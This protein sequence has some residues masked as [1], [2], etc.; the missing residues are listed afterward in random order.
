MLDQVDTLSSQSNDVNQN[1][2]SGS[3]PEPSPL[4]LFTAVSLPELFRLLIGQRGSSVR[5]I[6][7][8]VGVTC[9]YI[10]MEDKVCV[11]GIFFSE[12]KGEK[13]FS[14]PLFNEPHPACFLF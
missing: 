2:P 7:P 4:P 12:Q 10:F 9:F 8:P 6:S 3:S 11:E 5:V 14:F 1:I 13:L